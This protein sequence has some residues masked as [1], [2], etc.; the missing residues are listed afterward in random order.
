MQ[1]LI[2]AL[3]RFV[4]CAL[5]TVLGSPGRVIDIIRGTHHPHHSC[6]DTIMSDTEFP[7][8]GDPNPRIGANPQD[9]LHPFLQLL[10]QFIGT[11]TASTRRALGDHDAGEIMDTAAEALTHQVREL[12]AF[13]RE[14]VPQMSAGATREMN[15]VLR[16]QGGD[17]L[18]RGAIQ[19]ASGPLSPE[20]L[21]GLDEIFREIK[22]ILEKL[23]DIIWPKK[24]SWVKELFLLLDELL[25]LIISLLFPKLKLPLH[26]AEVQYL[27]ELYELGR[28]EQLQA[29]GNGNGD[30][31]DDT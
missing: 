31:D 5:R 29:R 9:L 3:I 24:P 23:L 22:K 2:Q 26:K 15:Q 30:D 10:E 8:S 11:F 12:G 16:M 21:L 7:T 4:R 19:A 13:L 28:L 14:G 25:R 1:R 17:I 6:G 27:R 18:L 20:K